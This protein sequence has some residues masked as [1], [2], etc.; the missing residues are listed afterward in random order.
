MARQKKDPFDALEPEF[1]DAIAGMSIE[2]IKKRV[3]E[4]ALTLSQLLEAK[5]ADED[6]QEK[7]AV[8]KMAGA[9]YREGQKMASLRIRYSQSIIEARGK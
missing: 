6:L 9:V 7:M 2:D 8:A 3:A 4:I 5:K 1:K